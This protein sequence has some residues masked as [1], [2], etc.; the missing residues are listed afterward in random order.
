MLFQ[1]KTQI[2]REISIMKLIDHEHCVKLYNVFN[3]SNHV[4]LVLEIMT[5]GELFDRIIEK[6]SVFP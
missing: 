4:Y 1:V 3:S 6:V 5:G 2:E